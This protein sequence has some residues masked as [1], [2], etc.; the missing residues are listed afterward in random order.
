MKKLLFLAL[1][2]LSGL[3]TISSQTTAAAKAAGVGANVSVKGVAINGSELGIIR[4]I[5]DVTGGIAAYGGAVS[6]INRGD[7]VLISGPLTEYYNL[8]EITPPTVTFISA[9][10]TLPNPLVITPSQFGE[11]HEGIL[12]KILNCTFAASGNFPATATNYTVTANS[13]TF[14]VRSNT[15]LSGTPIPTG[16]VNITGVGSQF[17]GPQS[18][19]G[20]VT[21]YQLLPRT[22]TDFAVPSL[23][24]I[25]NITN[26]TSVSV[27][28]NPASNSISFKLSND[29][30][31]LSILITDVL[32][33]TVYAST[34]NKTTLDISGV[35]K[36]FYHLLVS[37]EKN[38]YKT[39]F[40][41]E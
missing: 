35:S 2:G 25:D 41:V 40:I 1:V 10:A 14:A 12:I 4:Y 23:T 34:E 17:C 24:G 38:T 20:C 32:G 9:N 30:Q 7:S 5:Q 37:T 31:P 29:E 6:T 27:F 36:G 21:G 15:V 16:I 8:F 28:P 13:Q 39:K 33:K 26:S 11:V 19:S 18:S 3:N 22:L